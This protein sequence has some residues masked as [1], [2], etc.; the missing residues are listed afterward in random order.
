[1]KPGQLFIGMLIIP[2]LALF[3]SSGTAQEDVDRK[4]KDVKP[5]SEAERALQQFRFPDGVKAELTA[6]EPMLSNPVAFCI[7]DQGRFYVAETFRLN[8]GATDNRSHPDWVVDDLSSRTVADRIAMYRKF[9]KNRFADYG[10]EQDRVRMLADT[11]ND[12]KPDRATEFAAGFSRPEDG[13]GSGVLARDGKVWYA[14]IPDLWLLEDKNDDGLADVRKSLHTGYGVHVS[15]IGHDSHGL[16]FGPD[17]KLYFSVGDRGLHVV[18]KEGVVSAPDTG[19]VLRCNPDGTELELVATGLRNPQELAFDEYGNLFTGDNNADSGDRARWVH[20]VEGGDSGWRIG[21]Q[22]LKEPPARL[23]PWNAERLWHLQHP[24]QPAYIL[25]PLAHI[26]SGPSGLTYHPGVSL[27]PEKYRRHFFLCDFRGGAGESGIRAFQVEPNGAS[28]RVVNEQQFVWNVLATD[29]DF[30]PDGGLY[31][32]DWVAGWGMPMK[33]RIYRFFDPQRLDDERVAEVKTLLAEGMRK[34]TTSELVKLL[35]HEDMRIRQRAQFALADRQAV[36]DLGTVALKCE[37]LLARIHAVWGLGQVARKQEM[38]ERKSSILGEYL[39]PLLKDAE[40]ELRGQAVKVIGELRAACPVSELAPLLGDS[41]S[42]V[43][44]FAAM[45]LGKI[46]NREAVEPVLAMLRDND[47]RDVYLRHAG[48]M[49]LTWIG[50][51]KALTAHARDASR[52]VRMGVLLAM[53]RLKMTEIA[54]FLNDADPFLVA[55][56]ARAINDVP[57]EGAIP[58]L[59]EVA[60]R[61]GLPD[62]VTYRALNAHFWLGKSDN[63]MSLARYAARADAPEDMR[64]EALRHLGRWDNPPRLDRVTGLYRPLEPRPREEAAEAIR[65][66]LG[67]IFTGPSRVHE[68]GARVASHLGIREVG[69]ALHAIVSDGKRPDTVRVESLKAL[70]TLKDGGLGKAV[71]LALASDSPRLRAEG[72]N[73]LARENPERAYPEVQEA[74][75]KGELIEQQR[76]L[77]VLGTLKHEQAGDVLADWMKRL[78]GGKVRPELHLDLL[79]AA[80]KSDD[81]EVETLLTRFEEDRS[82]TDTLAGFREALHGGDAAAGRRIFMEKSEVSCL[83]CHKVAG[84]GGD[85]GPDLSFIAREKNR[86]YLLEAITAPSKEIAKGFDSVVLLLKDGRITTGVLKAEDG[87]E[88]RLMTPEGTLVTVPKANVEEQVR[89]KSAMPED[90][91]KHLQRRELRDL[92]EFLSSLK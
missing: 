28:F 47:D 36:K 70:A 41:S 80:A 48:V 78:L 50:D 18:T 27:L 40:P 45:A 1:M 54:A 12:G 49:A 14:C 67:G 62:A 8:R 85:V 86:E 90:L 74:L 5:L 82:K 33:G 17:G 46:G 22:Y 11:D 64:V 6:A 9:L 25:P 42:R 88:V 43:R 92:V 53:R 19:A 72:R 30:G 58:Q 44:F 75:Q 4:K 32:T 69:P 15:F 29:A 59:A 31:L 24:G 52:A 81:K 10:K 3:I 51:Q 73:V 7:D 91:T 21:Y 57:I 34:R 87:K 55:E 38:G 2:I 60:G 13:I 65:T 23:G 83:R 16:V 89:G 66:A 56:A 68:E 71:E 84:T 76:A 77:T 37:N 35:E 63:A 26:G 61:T 79:E 39:Q 20:V